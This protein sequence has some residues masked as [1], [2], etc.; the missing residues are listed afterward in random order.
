[1]NYE[2][3]PQSARMCSI[4]YIYIYMHIYIRSEG[5]TYKIYKYGII[6]SGNMLYIYYILHP[7]YHHMCQSVS[8][9]IYIYNLNHLININ[10]EINYK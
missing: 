10:R 9:Y 5:N 8:I 3:Y 2:I 7:I 1:M 6:I 4:I